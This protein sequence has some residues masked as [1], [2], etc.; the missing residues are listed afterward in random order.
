MYIQNFNIHLVDQSFN[1]YEVILVIYYN[2]F[3]FEVYFVKY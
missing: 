1:E 2:Q 3:S